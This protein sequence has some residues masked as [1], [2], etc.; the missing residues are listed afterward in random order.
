M[1]FIH[2]IGKLLSHT[3]VTEAGDHRPSEHAKDTQ[4]SADVRTRDEA[5]RWVLKSS[6]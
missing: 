2:F 5:D 6:L 1:F 3:Q 4:D